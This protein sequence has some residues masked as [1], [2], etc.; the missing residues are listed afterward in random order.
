LL[1][2][3]ENFLARKR[4][5]VDNFVIMICSYKN[6]ILERSTG[7][8]FTSRSKTKYF[9]A[10]HDFY[11]TMVLSVAL[12]LLL[13][14]AG[15]AAETESTQHFKM[16]SIVEYTGE[17][18]FR[19]QVETMFT[20]RKQL[21]DD[22]KVRYFL[23]ATDFDLVGGDLSSGQP[24]S[25][26][27]SFVV[28]RKTKRLSESGKALGFLENVNNQC[29]KN[30]SRVT[31][32]NVGK[33]WKQSFDLS[34]LGRSFPD[35]LK[36]TLKAIRVKTKVFGELIAVRALSKP[37]V[38]K[39]AKRGGGTGSVKSRI[40]AVYVFD[41]EIEDIYLSISVFEATT[42]I[43]GPKE[44]LRHE[45]ATYKTDAVGVSADLSGL[46]KKFEK[47]VRELRLAKKSFKVVKDSPL[48]QWAQYEV[49]DAAQVG[50]ISAAIACEG[51][52]NPV[53]TVCIPAARTVAMQS[54]GT[55][56]P[57]GGLADAGLGGT[58]TGSLGAGV[59][60]VGALNIAAGPAFLG[61]G[62]GVAAGTTATAVAVPVAVAG[63]GAGG[64]AGTV[65]PA[66]P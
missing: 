47:F 37:F 58:V 61:M 32:E 23:S 13:S 22:D 14:K 6:E 16:L 36:F 29:V 56:A 59:P 53:V 62:A 9:W 54:L 10:G 64:G 41:P 21:L 1:Q 42:K 49:L 52:P 63:G 48:P 4:K 2:K 26:E 44:K 25:E 45:V 60:A 24:S 8:S 31:R 27:L 12:L 17:G 30:L 57:V 15:L 19:N 38:V 34:S 40:G 46:G 5:N 66:S 18:Q 7:M 51:A 39:A 35:E 50:S 65:T 55:L 43:N 20:V 28:D 3:R 11:F 33:T